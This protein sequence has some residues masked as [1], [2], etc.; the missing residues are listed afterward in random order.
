[1]ENKKFDNVITSYLNNS[2]IVESSSEE[3][4]E[5]NRFWHSDERGKVAVILDNC[6]V[7]FLEY[8][9]FANSGIKR[10]HHYHD[11]Y[12]EYLYVLSGQIRV[13]AKLLSTGELTNFIIKRGDLLTIKPN[14]AHG[15]LSLSHAEVLTM[16]T[17]SNPFNDRKSFKEFPDELY[18]V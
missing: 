13:V 9:E 12:T 1:M 3:T 10:G 11:K 17:G 16:G 18:S 2:M 5:K 7:D 6:N 15:F 8:A 14:V 4:S